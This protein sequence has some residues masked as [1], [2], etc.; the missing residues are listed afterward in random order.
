MQ[1]S[2]YLEPIYRVISYKNRLAIVRFAKNIFPQLS[3]DFFRL[4]LDNISVSIHLNALF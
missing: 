3:P 2:N 1:S 4:S